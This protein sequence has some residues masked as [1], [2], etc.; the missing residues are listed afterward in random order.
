MS[1]CRIVHT[2]CSASTLACII[3]ALS[4]LGTLVVAQLGLFTGKC[5]GDDV[6]SGLHAHGV[7]L[8]RKFFG[9]V[10]L[11]LLL[12][13]LHPLGT[14]LHYILHGRAHVVCVNVTVVFDAC[15]LLAAHQV[16]LT[17]LIPSM[18]LHQFLLVE[19]HQVGST[20]HAAAALLPCLCRLPLREPVLFLLLLFCRLTRNWLAVWARDGLHKPGRKRVVARELLPGELVSISR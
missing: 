5:S 3:L 8:A 20:N 17:V 10:A 1:L 7:V 9:H 14:L 13:G 16:A 11:A 2:L 15:V 19:V 4:P 18:P 12:L 6:F